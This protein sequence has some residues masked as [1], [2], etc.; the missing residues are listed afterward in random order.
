MCGR[1]SQAPKLEALVAK[2]G[3][4]DTPELDLTPHYNGAPGQDFLAVRDQGGQRVLKALRWGYIPGW[5]ANKPVAKRLINA[6]SETV[7][8]KPSFRA[9]FRERRC[10]IPVNGWFEWRT[11]NG[12]KQP[13]WIRP[14]G[15]DVFSLAGIWESGGTSPGAVD[16]FVIL[17]MAAAQSRTSRRHHEGREELRCHV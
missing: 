12:E 4:G 1:I 3:V 10:V 2:Y 13:Y 11:E 7:H 17:T 16:T 8:Q 5:A 15:V 9:A 6:R 14:E